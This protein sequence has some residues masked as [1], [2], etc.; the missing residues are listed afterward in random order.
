MTLS[1]TKLDI[2]MISLRNREELKMHYII[3]CRNLRGKNK[4]C[5]DLYYSR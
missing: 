2:A 5:F 3:V 4:N 1:S